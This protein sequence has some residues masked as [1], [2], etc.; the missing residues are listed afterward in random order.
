MVVNVRFVDVGRNDESVF[1]F[2]PSHRCF[3]A[4][5]VRFIRSDFSRLKRLAYLVCDDFIRIT[6]AKEDPRLRNEV[7]ESLTDT[8]GYNTPARGAYER[9][10]LMVEIDV[11]VAMVLDMTLNQLLAAYRIQ[12]VDQTKGKIVVSGEDAAKLVAAVREESKRLS[13]MIYLLS[14][15]V[16][17]D[18]KT[19]EEYVIEQAYIK[20]LVSEESRNTMEMLVANRQL[21][22]EGTAVCFSDF[23]NGYI[24]N[25][26]QRIAIPVS[27]NG[28][29]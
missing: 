9:R 4:D 28:T 22:D 16:V 7:F 2:C 23:L 18:D 19:Q 10:Q 3:I 20:Q 6:W 24:R 29:T 8:W 27:I 5:L 12:F 26:K 17:K 11:L 1:A 13:A 21:L 15:I 25:G 14:N